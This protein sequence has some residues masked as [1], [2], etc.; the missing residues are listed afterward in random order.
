MASLTET[1]PQKPGAIAR[2]EATSAAWLA[3]D[4]DGP[5]R[6]IGPLMLG[7]AKWLGAAEVRGSFVGMPGHAQA[8]LR[9]D[10]RLDRA[11]LVGRGREANEHGLLGGNDLNR[12]GINRFKWLR[13]VTVGAS[14]YGIPMHADAVLKV[15]PRVLESKIQLLG[16]L[17]S[18]Q[19]K[20][21]GG[22]LAPN[23]KIYG[24]PCYASTVLCIDPSK[25]DA[26]STFGNVW[27][28]RGHFSG[29]IAAGTRI[30]AGRGRG[31]AAAGT[32][33]VRRDSQGVAAAG[34]RIL[35]GDSRHAQVGAGKAKWYGGILGPDGNMY[36][37]PFAATRVLR[38]LTKEDRAELI[39]P[40]L[41]GG[42]ARGGYKWHGGCLG[43]DG[44]VYGFPMN[45]N[46]V[47]RI[48]C[49]TG[50]VDELP[51]PNEE[52]FNGGKYPRPRRNLLASFGRRRL[53]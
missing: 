31:V 48:D 6:L 39:G 20:W 16:D 26:V 9:I 30:V 10:P 25:K 13:G 45:A 24:V 14:C 15:T 49:A 23:G 2:A 22:V 41:S 5:M 19:Y 11:T 52:T 44:R 42:G 3:K 34:T 28:P 50:A 35:R 46:S 21:H 12:H 40:E 32:R 27:A 38:V 51:L 37:V 17:P 7:K 4:E 33:I 18:S 53:L 29:R 43:P 8:I 1:A 47:L 36:C